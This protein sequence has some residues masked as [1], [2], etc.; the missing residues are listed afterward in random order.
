[1]AC[2][3]ELG[4]AQMPQS[5]CYKCFGCSQTSAHCTT[6][7]SPSSCSVWLGSGT[8]CIVRSRDCRLGSVICS[9]TRV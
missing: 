4:A 8:C 5:M 3:A 1:M 9:K 6:A 7:L 2:S